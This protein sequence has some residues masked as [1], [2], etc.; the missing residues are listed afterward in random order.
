MNE[1]KPKQTR[2]T[3]DRCEP[4][5]ERNVVAREK[6]K[7]A[8]TLMHAGA[9]GTQT[10]RIQHEIYRSSIGESTL[11]VLRVQH[12]I[13]VD[14]TGGDINELRRLARAFIV[15]QDKDELGG[16]CGTGI[17]TEFN[18]GGVGCGPVVDAAPIPTSVPEKHLPA[19]VGDA[20]HKLVPLLQDED[21]EK[22]T[23][24]ADGTVTL[25]RPETFQV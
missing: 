10:R 24:W 14:R 23:L 2:R 19:A 6:R 18:E 3:R 8:L 21:I 7:L 1:I 4:P 12:N 17:V 13:E 20:L 25:S 15:E 22:V 5:R 9:N 16:A 11:R